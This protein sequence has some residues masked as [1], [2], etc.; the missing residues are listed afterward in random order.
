V[1]QRWVEP[2][3]R[4]ELYE[5]IATRQVLTLPI[6]EK[7][8]FFAAAQDF[9]SELDGPF[10]PNKIRLGLFTAAFV[11][12]LANSPP[13]ITPLEAIDGINGRVEALKAMAAG[14]PLPEPNMEAP[15]AKQKRP[16]FVFENAVAREMLLQPPVPFIIDDQPQFGSIS[17]IFATTN[18]APQPALARTI[19]NSIGGNISVAGAM[20]EA[21]AVVDMVG[22]D[23]FDVYGP[24]GVVQV[25]S[26]LS[27]R[28][29][30]ALGTASASPDDFRFLEK[31]LQ[32]APTFADLVS[33]E[34]PTSDLKIRFKAAGVPDITS[35]S[36][37][38]RTVKVTVNTKNHR[39]QY[40]DS[41]APRTRANSLQ[42]E[43]Q[44]NNDCYLTIASLNSKG[45]VYLLLP[46]AGQEITGFLRNG[47]IVSNTNVLIPDSLA[48][49]NLAGFH[50]DYSPP[51]GIDR[52]I[53][54]CFTS[55]EAAER[56]RAQIAKLELG[57][58]LDAPL[59]EIYGRGATNVTP[60]L[61]P[62]QSTSNQALPA[63][64]S[65]SKAVP[66]LDSGQ[67]RFNQAATTNGWTAAKL[68]LTIG[69]R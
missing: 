18:G 17:A 25:A 66:S 57:R 61:G 27:R 68:T 13:T 55:L 6:S 67:D 47:L 12:V 36:I 26:G 62:S 7:H 45:D 23:S 43:V 16:M 63:P 48:D 42:L 40:Y 32:N 50:F 20:G 53:G 31:V 46:N 52:I 65:H 10:G 44:S 41:G 8:V 4:R 69:P 37:S 54:V 3:T 59:F 33:L 49:D 9:E 29:A 38:T 2:D 15:L 1:S 11:G 24:G 14:M 58:P 39:L 5:S 64:E 30:I 60:S 35:R 22:P 21:A 56:F 28:R 19:A 51:G 34:N